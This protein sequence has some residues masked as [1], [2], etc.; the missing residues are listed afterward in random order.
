M[1]G[2]LLRS[3][4][5]LRRAL[6]IPR[7]VRGRLFV[8]LLLAGAPGVLFG[9][10]EAQRQFEQ[11]TRQAYVEQAEFAR[12]AAS[13]LD[14]VFLGAGQLLNGLAS[15]GAV[16]EASRDCQA[17][18]SEALRGAPRYTALVRADPQGRLLCASGPPPPEGVYVGGETWFD[19][20]KGGA[21]FAASNLK[22]GELSGEPI[23]IIGAPVVRNNRFDGALS[24]GLRRSW[25][26]SYL[27]ES[28]PNQRSAA[29]L[30]DEMGAVVAFAAVRLDASA[31]ARFVAGDQAQMA[32]FGGLQ[33][34]GL[35]AV[36]A[37]LSA[38]GL[39]LVLVRPRSAFAIGLRAGLIVLS[40]LLV[41][42]FSI[43]AVW[44][45]IEAW[46]LRW[47]VYMTRAAEAFAEGLP[48]PA[49]NG[50]PPAEVR[51]QADAF[52]EAVG[53]SRARE[54]ELNRA[55]DSNLRL[56]RELHHRV[57]NNLQVLSSLSNRH[58]R[59]VHDPAVRR[60]LAE[61]RAQ[62]VAIALVYRFLHGPE[63]LGRIDLQAYLAELARQLH[64]LLGG[65]MR[66]VELTVE[67]EPAVATA[68]EV[69]A[70]GLIVAE[71][72]IGGYSREAALGE[73]AAV[74]WHGL[75][76]E[77][78]WRLEVQA[79]TEELSRS[80]DMEMI[81]QLARQLRADELFMRDGLLA[82]ERTAGA[83]ARPKAPAMRGQS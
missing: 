69:G 44:L 51:A 11:A 31:A 66:G 53:R 19:T 36:T 21:S 4:S 24:I 55:L 56:S 1:R 38:P 9:A 65:D 76:L 74:R 42:A 61:A 13:R 68:D 80:T 72:F 29:L 46:V 5:A 59:R 54:A 67:L 71:C 37:R 78:P 48:L 25:L 41:V 12:S 49:M 82:V 73:R 52:S 32:S 57:K 75:D 23:I 64:L 34:Q 77:G 33:S 45:A 8:T 14:T 63:D 10:L 6:Q 3:A 26:E 22:Q 27:Q 39:R 17:V 28:M 30:V 79:P 58:Q 40:P 16:R 7:T 15:V 47:H 18:L 81:R 60:A 50:S 2:G 35:T 62:L 83:P 43:T 20:L 70:L